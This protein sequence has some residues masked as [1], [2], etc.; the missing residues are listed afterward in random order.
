[1][2]GHTRIGAT[3]TKNG[4]TITWDP[5]TDESEDGI[6]LDRL[7]IRQILL[8]HTAKENQYNVVEVSGVRAAPECVFFTVPKLAAI[9]TRVHVAPHFDG[10]RLL[11]MINNNKISEKIGRDRRT[12]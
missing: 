3:L 5:K 11:L 12:K 8:G 7:H 6:N 4:A 1:M 2:N 10:P 9:S